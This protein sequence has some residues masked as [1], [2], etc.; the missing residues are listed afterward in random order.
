MVNPVPDTSGTPTAALRVSTLGGVTPRMMSWVI[1]GL[2]N[3][4]IPSVHLNSY[5]QP[6]LR[7]LHL[8]SNVPHPTIMCPP[9]ITSCWLPP[10]R[11][12]VG[13]PR[14]RSA[15][16]RRVLRHPIPG[17]PTRDQSL[18]AGHRPGTLRSRIGNAR[19]PGQAEEADPRSAVSLHVVLRSESADNLR[20][21]N[22]GRYISNQGGNVG[23]IGWDEG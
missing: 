18:G 20:G 13:G 4:T 23:E 21:A 3:K 17:L 14:T 12:C 22:R 7:N 5:R 2:P 6:S 1:L 16:Q 11:S 8:R 10:R 15:D 19:T 9:L